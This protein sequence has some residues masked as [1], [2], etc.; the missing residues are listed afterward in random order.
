M[1]SATATPSAPLIQGV[2]SPEV[3]V[4]PQTFYQATRRMRYP[5]QTGKA[6]AGI[7]SA[8]N[9]QLRQNGIVAGLEVRIYGSVVFGGTIGTTT[10]SYEWPDN[11]VQAFV[12]S[13]NGQSNLINARGLA[14][15]GL[16]YTLDA[17][18]ND[19][20]V[21]HTFNAA[22]QTQGTLSL[23]SEDWGTSSS[24]VM[25]PNTNVAATGT[26]TVDLTYFVPVAADQISLV[27]AVYAQ[28]AATSLNLTVQYAT[29]AQIISALGASATV[30]FTGLNIS[31]VGVVYSIPNV[32]GKYVVPDLSQFHQVAEY[33]LGGLVSGTNELNL[34]GVGVGR[35]LL[36][37]GGNIYSSSAPLAVND[38]NFNLFGWAYGGNDVPEQFKSGQEMRYYVERLTGTDQGRLWGYWWWDFAG[39]FALRDVVDMGSTTN[40]RVQVGL[41]S[42]P[43]SGFAMLTQET[44]FAAPVGA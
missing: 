21:S 6:I 34:T 8:D 25:A 22:T 44:L 37:V 31:V 36:R 16:E 7:G 24:N 5:M 29:Q 12:L 15:K 13:A 2:P 17:D 39:K 28:S 11:L 19:R 18:I 4:D 23:A 32:N 27:G 30:S 43:T 33:R 35:K 10:M 20:G 9:I 42:S 3:V 1:P 26:Y 14:I 41:V 40:L 38:T